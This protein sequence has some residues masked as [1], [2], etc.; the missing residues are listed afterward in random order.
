MATTLKNEEIKE[1]VKDFLD[2]PS[3]EIYPR[4]MDGVTDYLLKDT[5]GVYRFI[6]CLDLSAEIRYFLTCEDEAMHIPANFIAEIAEDVHQ[7]PDFYLNLLNEKV[8]KEEIEMFNLALSVSDKYEKDTPSFWH[9]IQ[10]LSDI[11]LYPKCIVAMSKTY[12]LDCLEDELCELYVAYGDEYLTEMNNGIFETIDINP[13]DEI[14]ETNSI[15]YLYEVDP[16]TLQVELEHSNKPK[17][18]AKKTTPQKRSPK[19][20]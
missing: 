5:N 13:L 10:K 9:T 20:G 8:T 14:G 17:K 19:K 7:V 18:E 3:L 12:D 6:Y 15:Y 16:M 1:Y 2:S 11:S 4:T